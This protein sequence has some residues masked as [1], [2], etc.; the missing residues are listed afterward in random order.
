MFNGQYNSSA[1]FE[2]SMFHLFMLNVFNYSHLVDSFHAA[3]LLG[4]NRRFTCLI[5]KNKHA[6]EEHTALVLQGLRPYVTI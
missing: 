1:C 3:N 5:A 4:A 6:S 2:F